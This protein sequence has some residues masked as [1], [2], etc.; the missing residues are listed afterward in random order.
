[1]DKSNYCGEE[2]DKSCYRSGRPSCCSYN[3]S[4]CPKKKPKCNNM[5]GEEIMFETMMQAGVNNLRGLKA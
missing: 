3:K 4:D 1:M 2:K 5:E